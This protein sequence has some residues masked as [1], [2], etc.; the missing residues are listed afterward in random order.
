MA[1]IEGGD[2]AHAIRTAMGELQQAS[3]RLSERM[4]QPQGAP[5]GNGGSSTSSTGSTSR[6]AGRM[7]WWMGV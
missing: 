4:D 1:V 6:T 3:Y 7:M 2:G 5:G